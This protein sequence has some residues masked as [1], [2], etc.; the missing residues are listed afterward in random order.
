VIAGSS[1][2]EMV[3]VMTVTNPTSIGADRVIGASQIS[4][5]FDTNLKKLNFDLLQTPFYIDPGNGER[6]PGVI[7]P[8]TGVTVPGG[9]PIVQEPQQAYGGIAFT[10]LSPPSFWQS[11]GFDGLLATVNPD[12]DVI[13]LDNSAQAK[14]VKI[15]ALVGT[16]I[17]GT[18]LG[19]DLIIDK[20]ATYTTPAQGD[21]IT[22][23]TTPI[24]AN[25]TFDQVSNDE[26]YYLI[27]VGMK[28]PQK[29]IGGQVNR[30]QG[31]FS[32]SSN[33]V[34]GIMG[35]YFTSGNF[36]QDT[37]SASITYTHIGEPQLV[38]E[39][40][41]RITH[42]DG[43]PPLVNELGEKNS[44][45]MEL[46]STIRPAVPDQMSENDFT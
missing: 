26:G 19:N 41:V 14:S 16:Q 28:M 42:A 3:N 7:Y 43:S 1:Q 23:L 12:N 37:G 10:Q 2:E 11:L 17:T 36:L 18:F 8:P 4:L 39:L 44:I 13:T 15:T 24:V 22:S 38:S 31:S 29:L 40:D 34:Q 45:F 27:E 20:G 5:N 33:K 25:R 21:V 6:V 30:G 35:K 46:I 32:T 9:N